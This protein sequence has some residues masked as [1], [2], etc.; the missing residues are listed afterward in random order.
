MGHFAAFRKHS[1]SKQRVF[2]H[3]S[4]LYCAGNLRLKTGG[5]GLRGGA[6]GGGGE[7]EDVG[8][9]GGEGDRKEKVNTQ[10]RIGKMSVLN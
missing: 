4:T 1:L 2:S 8:G 3:D 10:G 6:R 9:G 5:W 7:G